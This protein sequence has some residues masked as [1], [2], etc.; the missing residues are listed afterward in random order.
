[1]NDIKEIRQHLD[2]ASYLIGAVLDSTT[3]EWKVLN[4]LHQAVKKLTF[5]V[6]QQGVAT[7]RAADVASC[8]ANGIQP[9]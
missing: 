7:A 8:L 9:D 4:E 6:E 1:M 3:D 2:E 5:V